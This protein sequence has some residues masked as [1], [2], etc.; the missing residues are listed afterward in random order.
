[1]KIEDIAGTKWVE[2]NH[3]KVSDLRE[4]L[5]KGESVKSIKNEL[6]IID[7]NHW[8]KIA[9][10]IFAEWKQRAKH[11]DGNDALVSDLNQ[12][13]SQYAL[14]LP[15][16]GTK[17]DAQQLEKMLKENPRDMEKITRLIFHVIM[18]PRIRA[19]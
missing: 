16:Y 4:R 14:A 5:S 10:A 17:G 19:L 3:V 9:N 6:G 18:Q 2:P 7:E 1:M 13:L 11:P 8:H 15:V 12:E